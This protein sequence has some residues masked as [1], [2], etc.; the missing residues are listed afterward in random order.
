V[1]NLG[2]QPGFSEGGFKEGKEMRKAD[3]ASQ[4]RRQLVD[5][6][7][8]LGQLAHMAQERSGI[9][10]AS[11]YSRG[12]RCGKAGCRCTRGKLHREMAVSVY[13]CGQSRRVPL[14][15]LEI[16]DLSKLAGNYRRFRETRAEMV[17]TFGR[18]LKMF[19]QLG[20]IREVELKNLR[21]KSRSA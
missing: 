14:E 17:K 20:R 21:R 3:Q 12:R 9:V 11:L 5:S 15:G 16:E 8:H 10:R 6:L 1:P 7:D 13:H 2:D 19:D 18:L 4:C